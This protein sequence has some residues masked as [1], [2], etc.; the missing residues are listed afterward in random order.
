MQKV[1]C[2]AHLRPVKNGEMS[3][4]PHVV[5]S[6]DHACNGKSH[7]PDAMGTAV[8]SAF[9]MN[10]RCNCDDLRSARETSVVP[11]PTREGAYKQ[12]LGFHPGFNL[13]HNTGRTSGASG[14]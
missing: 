2:I 3:Q 7:T 5:F 10:G 11:G 12:R 6:K 14:H 13:T 4:A 8:A 9:R 1:A